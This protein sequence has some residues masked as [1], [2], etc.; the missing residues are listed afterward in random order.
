MAA[1]IKIK[2]SPPAL[3]DRFSCKGLMNPV[4]KGVVFSLCATWEHFGIPNCKAKGQPGQTLGSVMPLRQYR[5]KRAAQLKLGLS[6][7]GSSSYLSGKLF[8]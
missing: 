5:G 7:L 2:Y 3:D 8:S 1:H 6:T 4:F